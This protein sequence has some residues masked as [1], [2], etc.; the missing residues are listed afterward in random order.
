MPLQKKVLTVSQWYASVKFLQA[1][2]DIAMMH[3]LP[4]LQI[5]LC[6]GR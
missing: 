3:V 6:H 1:I 2:V 5:A 4:S